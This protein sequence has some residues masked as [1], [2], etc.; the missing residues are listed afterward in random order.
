MWI[1]T[2]VEEILPTMFFNECSK[3]TYEGWEVTDVLSSH[4][5]GFTLHIAKFKKY[6]NIRRSAN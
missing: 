1:Y 3:K 5:S 4:S 2:T 6:E